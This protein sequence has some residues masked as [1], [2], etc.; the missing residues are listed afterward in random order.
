[1]SD[2]NQK[3]PGGY[4]SFYEQFDSSL[5]RRLRQEAYGQDIGQHSWVTAE[6]LIL[7]IPRLKLSRTS[8]LLDFGCGPG[9]PL[10]FVVSQI[11]CR[12]VGIDLSA[13]AIESARARAA[14]FGLSPLVEFQ[15]GD[16]NEPIPFQPGSFSAIMS[17]DVILHLRDRRAVFNEAARLLT[18]GG[19]FLFSD[20]G[21]LTGP[22]SNEDI[23]RRAMHG[24]TQ[25]APDG[26]NESAL[27]L[28]GFQLLESIDCTPSLLC[29]ANGRL[30]SRIAHRAE[31]EHAEGE[32]YFQAQLRYLETVVALSERGAVSRKM[33]LAESRGAYPGGRQGRP[34]SGVSRSR[35][36]PVS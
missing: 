14:S 33:Y 26:F 20:A 8:R 12:A 2:T 23:F 31:L 1:M 6:E 5:M 17:I 24:F 4:D 11:G 7:D 27:E 16:L 10:T 28:A 30:E 21:V 9:G 25:F 19:R 32:P 13:P 3:H 22:I 34:A 18:P 15:V 36:S 35:R 29:N